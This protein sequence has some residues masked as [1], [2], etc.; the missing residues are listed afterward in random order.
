VVGWSD[1][2]EERLSDLERTVNFAMK[3]LLEPS[4]RG[5]RVKL[6]LVGRHHEGVIEELSSSNQAVVRL[7][8][9]VRL[10]RRRDVIEAKEVAL[11]D[12]EFVSGQEGIK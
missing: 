11:S 5:R 1:H 12:L 4:L 3:L 6:Y 9:P 8:P 7:D 10:Y 2:L